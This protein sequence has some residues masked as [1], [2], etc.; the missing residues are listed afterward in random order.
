MYFSPSVCVTRC[1]QSVGFVVSV[2]PALG[3][4]VGYV[5]SVCPALGWFVGYVVSV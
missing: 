3:G 2:C 5:V 4:S 1:L